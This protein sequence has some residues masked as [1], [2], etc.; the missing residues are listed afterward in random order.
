MTHNIFLVQFHKADAFHTFQDAECLYQSRSLGRG[1]VDL[2]HISRYDHLGVH[3][4]AGEE[5]L[6]LL[7]SGVLRFIQNYDCIIQ[8]PSA[9]KGEGSN[10]NDVQFH[11]FFQLGSRNHILQGIIQR[12]QIRVYLILHVTGQESKLL[13]GFHGGATEDDFLDLFIFE[14]TYG[15]GNG[16]IRLSRTGRTYGKYHVVL[17]ETFYQF[18]LIFTAGDDRFACHAEYDDVTRLFCLRC[19]SFDDIDDDLFFQ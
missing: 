9:H 19:I 11:V 18:K 8:R 17:G 12:L 4:H 15:K 6:D 7:G 1:Q 16:S 5:H 13:T 14:G 3:T 10:L 2:C